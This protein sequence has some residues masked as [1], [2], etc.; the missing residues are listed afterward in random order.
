MEPQMERVEYGKEKVFVLDDSVV[1]WRDAVW[2][3]VSSENRRV[4]P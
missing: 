4:V 1:F 3:V 2:H